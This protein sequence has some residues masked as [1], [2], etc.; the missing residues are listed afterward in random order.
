MLCFKRQIGAN[1][2]SRYLD[3]KP[4]TTT[5]ATTTTTAAAYYYCYYYCVSP[6]RLKALE[7]VEIGMF[8][9]VSEFCTSPLQRAVTVSIV[10]ASGL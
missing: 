1:S 3:F 9:P 8:G 6:E 10:V 7:A 5:A 2:L 4:N